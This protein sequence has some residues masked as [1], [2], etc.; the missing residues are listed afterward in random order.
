YG[1]RVDLCEQ[2]TRTEI[3]D[4]I[5]KWADDIESQRQIFWLNDAAGTGKSTIA[6]TMAKDWSLEDRLAGRFFFSPNSRTT[7]STRE[8]CQ[9]VAEDIARNHPSVANLIRDTMKELSPDQGIWFDVQFQRLIIEPVKR[10]GAYSSVLIVIDALDNC[11]ISDERAGLLNT[12]IRHLPSVRHL[13]LLLT[14]RPVPDITDTLQ[15]SPLVHGADIQLLNVRNSDH[16]DINLFVEKRLKDMSFED[17]AM[18]IARSG[19]LFLYAATVCRMLERSRSRLDILKIISNT[20][21]TDKLEHRMDILY[22][23]LLKQALVDKEAVDMMLSVL[24]MIIVAYQPLSSNS[25]RQFLPENSHVDDFVQDLRSVL[26]DGHPDR[27]IKVLHPTFRDFILSNED[28]ANGFLI[29]SGRSSSGMAHACITILDHLLGDDMFHLESHSHL[30]LRNGDIGDI[31][32]LIREKTTAA[33]RYASAFWAHHVAASE[34]TPELWSKVMRFLSQKYLNWVELMSWRG[35]IGICIEGLSRLREMV[36]KTVGVGYKKQTYCMALAF[37]PRDSSIFRGYREQYRLRQ[38]EVVTS[39]DV[40]WED[41]ITLRGHAISVNQ[42]IFSPDGSRLISIDIDGLLYLWNPETGALI[43]KP[44][45]GVYW[46]DDTPPITQCT[47]SKDGQQFGFLTYSGELHVRYSYNGEP[48]S[49]YLE[50]KASASYRVAFS[51]TLSFAVRVKGSSITRWHII[52]ENEYQAVGDVEKDF[53]PRDIAISPD[54]EMVVVVGACKDV[55]GTAGRAFLWDLNSCMQVQAYELEDVSYVPYKYV[56]ISFSPDS[57]RFAIASPERQEGAHLYDGKAGG[58]L[59]YVAG[60]ARRDG[61]APIVFCPLSR[62]FAYPNRNESITVWEAQKV[63]WVANLKGYSGSIH[64]LSFS[65]DGSRIASI[66][67]DQTVRVWGIPTGES[68]DTIFSGYTGSVNSCILSPDW[69]YLAS[70]MRHSIRLYNVQNGA[71]GKQT[72]ESY[73]H[74]F[75]H[76]ILGSNCMGSIIALRRWSDLGLHLWDTVTGT[77]IKVLNPSQEEIV[78]IAF[79]PDG[80]VI[81]ALDWAGAIFTWNAKTLEQTRGFE[82]DRLQSPGNRHAGMLFS[83]DSTLLGVYLG[84]LVY[85]WEIKTSFRLLWHISRSSYI[86]YRLPKLCAISSDN[87]YAA[88]LDNGTTVHVWDLDRITSKHLNASMPLYRRETSAAFSPTD[89]SLL[90]LVQPPSITLW[91]QSGEELQPTIQIKMDIRIHGSLNFSADGNYLAYGPL[92]WDVT[93]PTTPL[94]YSGDLPPSSFNA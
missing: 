21:V 52:H 32:Q 36:R 54:D 23:S 28:R 44:F 69:R 8:F 4:C 94:R 83:S 45:Q 35:S 41:H 34:M 72:A 63:K 62:H 53:E 55:K 82:L 87:S 29:H 14:S 11:V 67:S 15:N 24:S 6:A 25:I 85:V 76:A 84:A 78:G 16:P 65:L 79:S 10:L 90:A 42:L 39:G 9:I 37:T 5:T 51:S 59:H 20:G 91:Q 27:P 86:D 74:Y 22:L 57:S 13:K 93:T 3:L 1:D 31:D 50:W 80:E 33:E 7:Q 64:H 38:P 49:P 70:T 71:S 17:R 89:S 60:V 47:F 68:L 12:L 30:P 26:K 81:A 48:V 73:E 40:D 18:I 66:A 58:R 43:G 46:N 19:G 75:G 88:G 77:T 2:G 61:I 92:C 56:G